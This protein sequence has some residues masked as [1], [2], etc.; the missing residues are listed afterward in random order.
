MYLK[1]SLMKYPALLL[2]LFLSLLPHSRLHAQYHPMFVE[3]KVWTFGSYTYMGG[4]IQ[5]LDLDL[6]DYNCVPVSYIVRG[7]TVINGKQCH[8]IY[9]QWPDRISYHSSWHE[10]N[11]V[12]EELHH[13]TEMGSTNGY[14]NFNLSIGDR[15]PFRTLIPCYLIN[16]DTIQVKGRLFYRQT[17]DWVFRSRDYLKYCVAGVGIGLA[18]MYF[19]D[20]GPFWGGIEWES[21][22]YFPNFF[23]RL[24]AVYENGE[25]IFEY[26]DFAT[27]PYVSGIGSPPILSDNQGKTYDLQGRAVTLPL[28]PGVYIRDGRKFVMK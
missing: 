16:I 22:G 7:D 12:A 15:S 21:D 27:E 28:R 9:K 4:Q 5:Y 3:G 19:M 1:T 20:G 14:L 11:G 6:S 8:K 26:T 2:F 17:Y 13:A 23:E 18:D 25:C 24:I 10:E